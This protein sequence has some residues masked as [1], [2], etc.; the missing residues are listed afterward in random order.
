M[1]KKLKKKGEPGHRMKV[2]CKDCGEILMDSWS[3]GE[4]DDAGRKYL[5]TPKHCP[6]CGSKN[7]ENILEA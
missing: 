2:T 5:D 4:F 3:A 1:Y 7:I 6:T